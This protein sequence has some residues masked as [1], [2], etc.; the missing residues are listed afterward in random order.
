MPCTRR[1]F[2]ELGLS[3]G[4]A[5]LLAGGQ[6][7][8]TRGVKAQPRGKPS[9]LPY[10]AHFVDVGATAGL[11]HPTIYGGTE[12]KDYILETI[13]CGCAFFDYDNDGWLDIFILSGTRIGAELHDVS[14]R[15]YRNNRDGTFSDVTREAGL[16]SLGWASGVCIGDYNNDGHED[17]FLTQW[18]QNKLYRNNG[19]GTFTD[20]TKEAGLLR[21]GP[22]LWGSGCT[23]TDYNRDGHLD[24]FF[25]TYV[26]FDFE[27]APKPSVETNCNFKGVPVNCGPRGLPYGRHFF[28][29]NNGDGTFTDVTGPSGLGRVKQTYGLNAVAADFDN[30][31][32]PDIYVACDSTP[33]V[34]FMNNHDGTFREEAVQ[35][36][37]AFSEDGQEQAGMGVG[38]G[39]CFL[40]GN[41]SLFKTHFA[42]DTNVLY[43]NR[44]KAEFDDVTSASRI[45]V[46]TRF[47]GWGAAIADLSNN[48]F[49][50]LM[51]VTG[52]VYPE[53]AAKLPDYPL[54]TPRVVFRNLGNGTFEE[55]IAEAGPG[56]ATPH[57]SRG[58]A[59]GDFDNDGDLDALIVNLNEP[60]SLLRNDVTGGGN[61]LKVKLTG[62]TSNRSAI[63]AQVTARYGKHRQL[64]E[65]LSQ[66]SFLS[67]NDTRLHFGMGTAITADLTVRWPNGKIDEFHDVPSGQLAQ[68]DEKDGLKLTALPS[69]KRKGSAASGAASRKP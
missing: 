49:P 25:T 69:T 56:V 4:L 26:G 68:I 48:G 15:L 40:D 53:I 37:A 62:R 50:D 22:P 52:N 16:W 32:W 31:G 29:R 42:D 47:I 27:H 36:G 1:T 11:V 17:L 30:D 65:V 21:S 57:C 20:I 24:L 3:A 6:G 18:G 54:R 51:Y 61:W 35:R 67:V 13:G 43:R 45:G 46:E 19:N 12:R 60:P 28:Y 58:L 10:G 7:V 33:S 5:E 9:G 38:V 64:Q 39:D 2:L 59:L 34:L 55:L 44:G 8:A 23:F 41:L 66:S 63:G 14:N